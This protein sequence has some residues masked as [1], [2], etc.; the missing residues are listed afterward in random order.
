MEF[1]NMERKR[2]WK[3]FITRVLEINSKSISETFLQMGVVF[4]GALLG[5]LVSISLYKNQTDIVILFILLAF[6]FFTMAIVFNIVKNRQRF[7]KLREG[8]EVHE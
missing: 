1:K 3:L 2:F 6:I 8:K 5:G 7:K 4:F